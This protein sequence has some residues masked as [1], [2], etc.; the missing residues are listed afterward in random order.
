MAINVPFG[1]RRFLSQAAFP[2]KAGIRPRPGLTW[3]N[4][5]KG[6]VNTLSKSMAAELGPKHPSERYLPGDGCDRHDRTV[7]PRARYARKP[8]QDR[9]G[10]T[11]WPHVDAGRC[12]E[13]DALSCLRRR[14]I[15][16]WDRDA[17][18]RRPHYSTSQRSK[19][20][21]KRCM[22][23]MRS[24]MPHSQ[25]GGRM[26]TSFRDVHD[27]PMALN[28]YVWLIKDGERNILVDPGFNR[29]AGSGAI[30]S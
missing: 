1:P 19:Y 18:R 21:I 10:D 6:A 16:Y 2:K 9:C 29:S 26:R 7:S 3:Y 8:R 17:C 24:D 15:H 12:S 23:S 13:R 20:G 11:A 22:K 25:S 27:G 28:F 30:A 14:Q 4:A 5:S